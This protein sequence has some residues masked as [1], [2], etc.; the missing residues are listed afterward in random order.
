MTDLRAELERI[1]NPNAPSSAEAAA[2]FALVCLKY[3]AEPCIDWSTWSTGNAW[4]DI[5]FRGG[6]LTR[7]IF[8]AEHFAK[9]DPTVTEPKT[10]KM[11]LVRLAGACAADPETAMSAALSNSAG[12][13]VFL[14][15]PAMRNLIVKQ[16]A[17]KLLPTQRADNPRAARCR[18]AFLSA[19]WDLLGEQRT[20][21]L[22]WQALAECVSLPVCAFVFSADEED[23]ADPFDRRAS[24][25]STG[26]YTHNLFPQLFATQSLQQQRSKLGRRVYLIQHQFYWSVA[27][28]IDSL[29]VQPTT[30]QTDAALFE[31]WSSCTSPEGSLGDESVIQT[32]FA[33]DEPSDVDVFWCTYNT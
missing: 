29:T 13:R 21:S 30:V 3:P 8:K 20:S 5:E 2:Q 6:K 4:I 12:S 22:T 23:D 33:Q 15:Q 9:L 24:S 27:M 10:C 32:T 7:H 31:L 18:R 11:S 17:N 14:E 25:F 28:Y 16:L 19:A 1:W 26:R